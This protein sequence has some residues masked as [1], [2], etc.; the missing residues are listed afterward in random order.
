M[1]RLST[2]MMTQGEVE[3]RIT[4]WRVGFQSPFGWS[5]DLQDAIKRCIES[6][7]NPDICI[8]PVAVAISDVMEEAL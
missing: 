1:I 5:F 4:E 2:Q 7:L 8:R 6:D 3:A